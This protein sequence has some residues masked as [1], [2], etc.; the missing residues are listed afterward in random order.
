M[1]CIVLTPLR[2]PRVKAEGQSFY[3]CVSRVVDRRLIS[4]TAGHG[5]AEA[6]RS[7]LLLNRTS[8]DCLA[9]LI[10]ASD[11]CN[12]FREHLRVRGTVT[13]I[14]ANRWGDVIL[15]F[16][17][18]QEAFKAVIP[19][20]CVRSKEKGWINSLKNRTLTVSALIS[21]YAQAPAIRIL[22]KSQIALLEE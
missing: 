16:G 13:E 21:F 12:H 15:R 22:E 11:A 5:S 3:H 4:Q 9:A 2:F 17:S 7:V 1:F 18:T 19:A 8:P 14:G 6:E 10:D 20:S